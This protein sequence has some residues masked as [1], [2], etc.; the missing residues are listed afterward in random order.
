MY[1]ASSNAR[2]TAGAMSS[3]S[4]EVGNAESHVDRVLMVGGWQ[5]KCAA[6]HVMVVRQGNSFP[7]HVV[8]G[9]KESEHNSKCRRNR[10]TTEGWRRS[11]R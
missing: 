3:M 9:G 6:A 11:R 4:R 8:F 5:I 2:R 10:A 1:A 7:D